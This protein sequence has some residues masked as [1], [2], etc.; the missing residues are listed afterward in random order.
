M[1]KIIQVIFFK[2]N[3]FFGFKNN[4]NFILTIIES[5]KTITK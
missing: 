1:K 4:I 3:N 5:I 2:Y